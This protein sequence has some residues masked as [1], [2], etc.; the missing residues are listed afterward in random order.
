MHGTMPLLAD[1]FTR[2]TFHWGRIQSNADWILPIAACLVMVL[3]V[4]YLYRRDAVELHPLW[5]WLLTLLR[6]ATFF[7]LLI[8]FLQPQWRSEREVVRNSRVLLL[9]DTSLSMGLSDGESPTSAAPVSRAQQVVAALAD[10][11]FLARLRKVHDVAVFPFSEDLYRDRMVSLGKQI[12]PSPVGRGAGGEGLDGER[13]N[14]LQESSVS[15]ASRPHPNPLPKG[16][17]T[18]GNSPLPLGEGQGVRAAVPDWKKL[19]APTGVETRLGQALRQLLQTE[20]G[21]PISG[22]VVL[23]DGGQNAGIAPGAAVELA[24]EAKIPV[25]TVGLGSDRPPTNL[26][27]CDL[28]V[29]ARAYPGDHYTVTGYVQAQGMAGRVATVQLLERPVGDMADAARRGT[30]RLVETRQVTLGR[31]GEV[32]AVKFELTP[33]APGRRTL[34]FRVQPLAGDRNPTDNLREADVEIVDRKNHV[35]LLA[36][37]P[38]REYHFLR[39]QLYRDHSTVLDVLLQSGKPGMSQEARKILTD[40]PTTREEMYDY[41][42]VVAFDPNWLALSPAQVE[43]LEK[44]VGDQG[45]GLIVIAGAVYAGK[46]VGGWTENAAMAPIRN[47][48]PVEFPSRLAALENNMYASKEPWPLSFTR[49]GLE[50]DFLGLGDTATAS[51]QAWAGFPGV[52][53]YCPVRGPK[54]GATVFARFSDPRMAQGGQQPLYFAGQFYGT[55]SVFYLGSGEMWRLRTVDEAYFE[56]FYTKLIRHVSQG[57]LLRGSRRG[58]LLVGQ[59]RYMVGN[60]V[61][62]RA[63]LSNARLVPLTLPSVNLQVMRPSGATQTIALPADPTRPGAY[64]GQFPAVEEGTYRLDLPVPES[65]GER[66]TRRIQVRVADLERE[67]PRRNDALL[68]AI[69]KNTGGRYYVGTR[70]AIDAGSPNALARQ[71]KDQTNTVIQPIA[72]NP[73][74]EEAWLRWMMVILC[75]LLCLE[76]LI[77]RLLKLA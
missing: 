22:V 72:P 21:G 24:A 71:L 47:L 58:V 51:R 7:G 3:F 54:P 8:L 53:G 29:P 4:R 66:L 43:L 28:A 32:V 57:R 9:V 39:S 45:G 31:D 73:Q 26:S 30:G 25:F 1:G 67:N 56:Q 69:A 42:C 44:W 5:G 60:T 19:L 46:G 40:F 15:P 2:T 52:Y 18:S 59:D 20:R 41:D 11:D 17:G 33:D 76:W 16:E 27:V 74:W 12:L 77:R 35:L 55:G 37:G 38:T 61:E 63:Q 68:S 50:A 36:G 75:S 65:S 10:T 14:P 23:S 13:S 6:A 49:E 64:R 70:S 48:Y 62:V 34:C